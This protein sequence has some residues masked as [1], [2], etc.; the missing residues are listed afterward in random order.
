[1]MSKIQDVRNQIYSDIK[2][3]DAHADRNTKRERQ[4]AIDTAIDGAT[5]LLEANPDA[6]LK[7]YID[8]LH[9]VAPEKKELLH[10]LQDAYRT[11]DQ[12]ETA[13]QAGPLFERAFRGT[14]S[15]EAVA[16]AFAVGQ[17]SK[18]T[19]KELRAQI[20]VTKSGKG[21]KHLVQDERYTKATSALKKLFENQMGAYSSPRHLRYCAGHR[22]AV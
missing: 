19:A 4:A 11:R 21:S 1:V 13:A 18:D 20:R 3:E 22:V 2:K 16:D 8:S 15:F 10:R 17:I 14:L 5:E 9:G 12:Q 6:D 7:P